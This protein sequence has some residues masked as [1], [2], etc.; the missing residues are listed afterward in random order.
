MLLFDDS[1]EILQIVV[2]IFS[3]L[4]QEDIQVSKKALLKRSLKPPLSS[5]VAKTAISAETDRIFSKKGIL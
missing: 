5:M 4:Y 2:Q 3:L 1:F